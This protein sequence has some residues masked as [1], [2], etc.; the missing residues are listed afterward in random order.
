ML[1]IWSAE[2]TEPSRLPTGGGSEATMSE[3]PYLAPTCEVCMDRPDAPP[4]RPIAGF[5]AIW[6]ESIV[7]G[8]APGSTGMSTKAG[9]DPGKKRYDEKRLVR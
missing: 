9:A 1:D 8:G 3:E 2:V 5:I 4:V 7:W 6:E